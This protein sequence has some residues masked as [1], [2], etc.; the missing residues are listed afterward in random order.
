MQYFKEFPKI[1]YH[2]VDTIDMSV[3]FKIIDSLMKNHNSYYNYYW[4][5]HDRLDVIA[6]KYYGDPNLSWLV[7]LSGEIF[8]W[9]YDLPLN[10]YDFYDYLGRKYPGYESDI[11]SLKSIIHH[12]SDYSGSEVD[13]QTYDSLPEIE[14]GTTSIYQFEYDLNE[15]KRN[16]KL[17]SKS[18]VPEIIKEFEWRLQE[19]K[20]VR[21]LSNYDERN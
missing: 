14:R 17:I 7:M 13:R 16:I 20:N 2:G 1:N 15:S 3:R 12:Y 11:D 6:E 18:L 8:D 5:D 9:I 4:Q 19:I 10:S 21:R